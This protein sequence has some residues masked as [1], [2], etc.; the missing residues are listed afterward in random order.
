MSWLSSCYASFTRLKS[1]FILNSIW[2]ILANLLQNIFFSIFFIIVARNYN[3]TD[4]SSYILANT[5]Y[6]LLLAFSS[7]GLGQWFV[8]RLLEDMD[9]EILIHQFFKLQCL[10]GLIFYILIIVVTFFLYD[11]HLLRQLALIIGINI[12]FD[13]II[14]V[15]KHINIAQ[16]DQKKTF[17]IQTVE[18]F[19]KLM[20]GGFI[21]LFPV[22]MVSLALIIITLRFLTLNVFINF[23]TAFPIS[24]SYLYKVKI[25]IKVI[26][27]VISNN[28]PFI[29]I[30][31]MSVL[32]WKMG[33][34][35][36]ANYLTLNEVSH[37]E[38]SFK[39]FSMAEVIPVIVSTSIFPVL[40]KK[41]KENRVDAMQFYNKVFMSY[42][43]YGLLSFTFIYSFS[44]QIVPF[45]FG[46]KYLITAKYCKEMFFT[47]LVFPTAILQANLMIALHQEKIDM[48]LNVFSLMLNLIFSLVGL[49]FIKSIT[50]IN[51]SIF[52]SFLFFHLLQDYILIKQQWLSAKATWIFYFVIICILAIYYTAT[53][54]LMPI[55]SFSLIWLTI[56][57]F[58]AYYLNTE[59]KRSIQAN[60]TR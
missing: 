54:F 10:I 2:G 25:D 13:N 9:K 40:L 5:I 31:S 26:K 48:W 1:R 36:I 59:F 12:I 28:W 39:L 52:I 56:A 37:Y 19:L 15:I 24:F 22:S 11:D 47:M 34:L 53:L 32:Y 49:Y 58:V 27:D 51:V 60:L 3:A 55:I 50:I 16:M 38:I 30:G 35:F 8:R 57:G 18:S 6:G 43:L 23:G 29:V 44:D 41:L 14:Y 42:A 7:L 4:F 20:L 46:S 33:N 21:I 45:L 17:L